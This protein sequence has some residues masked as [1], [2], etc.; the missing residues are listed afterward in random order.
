MAIWWCGCCGVENS[1]RCSC[2]SGYCPET[3]C[4]AGWSSF[5]VLAI[6]SPH[7][8]EGLSRSMLDQAVVFVWLPD[9][10][11]G[12]RDLIDR[13]FA[14]LWKS[15]FISC[16]TWS[17]VERQMF[18]AGI[19]GMSARSSVVMSYTR[20]ITYSKAWLRRHSQ[21]EDPTFYVS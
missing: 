2:N 10:S 15:I 13:S 8:H 3:R 9:S 19:C 4:H 1:R 18:G 6:R 20:V 5:E 21:R 7:S 14:A 17:P 16:T 12:R 11:V